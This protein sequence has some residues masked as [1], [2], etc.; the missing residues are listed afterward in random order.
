MGKIKTRILGLEDVEEKQK[1]E[2]KEKSKQ[3]KA[4]KKSVVK[5][6]EVVED[7]KLEK[8]SEPAFAKATAGKKKSTDVK[9]V[10]VRSR[11]K[12]YQ[13]A[14]K[15]ID[16]TKKYSITEAI[17]ILKKIK[18]TKINES[19]ELHLNVDKTGL[20]G[21][22]ELPYSTGK[23]IRIKIVDDKLLTDLEKGKIEFDILITHPSYMAKLAK[24]AKVLG[25]KG[26]MPNPKAGTISQ[27]PEDVAKKFEKGMLHWKTEPKFP[28]IHQMIGKLTVEDKELI[29]NANK[30]LQS[31]GKIHVISAFVK[32]TMSPSIKLDMEKS[33]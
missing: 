18:F 22:V 1:K 17:K 14:K 33:F 20:K 28:L 15:G 24:F 8:K 30:F 5:K 16:R 9:K 31:V 2:Q 6:E 19:V 25:P 11:G 26:L 12:A 13:K 32:S 21:E 23:T 3:K 29:E 4:E 10:V 27:N 7:K